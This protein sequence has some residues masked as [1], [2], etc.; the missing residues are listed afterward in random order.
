MNQPR[1][2]ERSWPTASELAEKV[3]VALDCWVAQRFT[4]AISVLSSEVALQ[5]A[6]KILILGGAAAYR[7]DK[8]SSFDCGLFTP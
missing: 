5:F 8:S 2:G 6:E 4:A 7:C 1:R 3:S